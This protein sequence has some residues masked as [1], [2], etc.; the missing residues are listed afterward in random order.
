V[1]LLGFEWTSWIHGHRH[2]LYFTDD[3][4]LI[5]SLP[6]A[7]DHPSELW[8]A[9]A[10]R[11]ALTFAHHSAGGPIAT[12][13]SIAP[14]PRFE[15]VTEVASVH[16]ASEALDAPF[17]IGGA[18]PGSTVRDA[19][20]RGH[21]LG[22]VGS[23]D[24]H[25]GHPGLSQLSAGTGGLAAILAEDATREAVLAALRARRCWA[26]NGPRILLDAELA[27]RA[28]GSSIPAAELAA[29]AELRVRV[30]APGELAGVELIRAGRSAERADGGRRRELEHTWRLA[31]L[32]GG[33]YVYVRAL[34]ADGGAAWSSPWF[35][36]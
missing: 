10:G 15:P 29:G 33:E 26:T 12:D 35:V 5:S 7:S 1:T 8:A 24:G 9:L 21:R 17:L 3:G 28:M 16:G 11:E 2:V 19:L 22:F 31:D 27:G 36:E 4:P 34:Q 14:D 23:G 18:L 20:G 6:E 32:R 30:V 13:W 25:D